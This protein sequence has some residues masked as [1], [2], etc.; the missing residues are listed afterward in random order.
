MNKPLIL[1][2]KVLAAEIQAGL[3]KRAAAIIEKTG[4]TPVLATILVGDNPASVTYVRMKGNACERVGIKSLKVV[5]PESTT[6]EELLAEIDKLNNDKNVSG[7]LLQHPVPGQIDE[8]KCFNAIAFEKDTDG[9]NISSFGA[10]SMQLDSFASATPLAIMAI[11][12]RYDIPIAGKRAVVIGRSPILGKPV[13]MLL[14]NADATVTICH[15]KTQELPDIVRT[16]DIIVAA[17]G[18]PRFVK[19]DWVKEGAVII[20][21]GYNEGNVG[22]VDLE[23]AAPKSSAY[24]PV[25]GGVGPVTII[26]LIEQTIISAERMYL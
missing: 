26:K 3:Q 13:A 6:T 8:Q 5:L 21:A 15:S 1:D 4:I 11:L 14:L 24:T 23:N 9:V 17:V 25:P 16:A 7:I 10:M 18:R 22:D 20:D 12:K 2:G 19:A